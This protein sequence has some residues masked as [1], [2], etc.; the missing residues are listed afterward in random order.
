MLKRKLLFLHFG[1]LFSLALS[2][3]N[4]DSVLSLY[5]DNYQPEKLHLHFDKDV[6]TKGETIWFKAYIR[7]GEGLSDYSRNFFVDWYDDAGQLISHNVHPVFESS[8]RGQFDVP[9]AYAGETIHL[10]AYTKW[11]LN[12][13]TAFIYTKDIQIAGTTPP[14][15]TRTPS[16]ATTLRFFPE[17]GDLVNGVSSNIAFMATNQS[18]K[19]VAVRGAILNSKN[20]LIDSFVSVHDGMGLFAIDASAKENYTCNW[21][22]EYGTSHTSNLPAAKN[23]GAVIE[24]KL[25]DD[26]IVF[27]VKRPADAAP[28]L[29]SLHIIASMNQQMVFS[30]AVNLGSKTSSAGQIP[31]DKLST[32][33]VQLTLFDANWLPVAERVMFVKSDQY[34]FHPEISIATKRLDKRLKNEIDIVVPDTLLSN[35]S[36]SI[37]DAGLSY[38]TSTNIF[39]QLLLQGDIKGYIHNAASYFSKDD[40]TTRSNLDLV[41]LT[42]GWRRYKWDDIVK[43]KMPVM[44]YAIDSDYVRIKGKVFTNG[45]ATIKPGQNMAIIMLGK[46]SS[47][48][49]FMVPVNPNGAFNQRGII[50]YDTARLFYQLLTEKGDKKLNDVAMVKFDYGLPL[51]PYAMATK[52]PRFGEPDSAMIRNSLFYAGLMKNRILDTGFTLKEV[53]VQSKIKSPGDIMDEKYTTGLFSSKNGYA[54]DVLHDER[55]KSQLD[56]FHYLQ[57]MVPGMAMSIPILGQNG[58]EDAN[59]NNV[60]GITWRDGTPDIFLNEMPS[61]VERLMSLQM[62][63]IAYIKVY[64]PPFMGSSGAGVSGAIAVYTRKSGDLANNVKGLNNALITGYSPYKEFY[65]P[66][67]SIFQSRATDVRSTLY[68]NPYVLTDKKNK[69]VKLEF[70]NNDV[71]K[72]MRIVLEG[73]NASGKLARVEKII[74]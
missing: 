48:Q 63:D 58:A 61:D 38:D 54:F 68:W 5:H 44:P 30:A 53:T 69:S 12:F 17:G 25:Q 67:Y 18:G 70:Y 74:E 1:M 51:V 52:L 14:K 59:S 39:S 47:K 8:A 7:A 29:R 27:V 32:G 28:N 55:A 45:Q 36:V 72:R 56:I 50:F 19:P 21:V 26:K 24:S 37:T 42:H 34:T 49:Y 9:A 2:A 41:M 65:S 13:D 20:E 22:D 15:N 71:T 33:V 23:T 60:P 46:D 16:L 35:L 11:M 62:A 64:R 66:D 3:Q 4:I 10:K 57:N 40:E 73:V 43:G 31:T 6:Y